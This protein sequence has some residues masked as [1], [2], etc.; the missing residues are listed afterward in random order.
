[1]KKQLLLIFI[2]LSQTIFF[3]SCGGLR[4]TGWAAYSG[5]DLDPF[6]YNQSNDGWAVDFDLDLNQKRFNRTGNGF[7]VM[8]RPNYGRIKLSGGFDVQVKQIRGGNFFSAKERRVRPKRI[9]K[10]VTDDSF[11]GSGVNRNYNQNKF[12]R[13]KRRVVK[14]NQFKN[15]YRPFKKRKNLNLE[16]FPFETRGNS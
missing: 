10:P 3:S 5:P 9:R 8:P 6:R 16:L 11:S 15:S 2:I 4:N 13:R 12:D 7:Y 1:M 14:N